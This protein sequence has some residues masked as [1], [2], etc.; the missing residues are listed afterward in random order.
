MSDHLSALGELQV[1]TGNDIAAAHTLLAG[2]F[3]LDPVLELSAAAAYL[4][5]GY[6]ADYESPLYAYDMTEEPVLFAIFTAKDEFPDIY[7]SLLSALDEKQTYDELYN[8]AEGLY[9]DLLGGAVYGWLDGMVYG[10][11]L[12]GY[13][14]A[15]Y[16][17]GWWEEEGQEWANLLS[18][19]FDMTEPPSYGDEGPSLWDITTPLVIDLESRSGCPEDCRIE[20]ALKNG[21]SDPHLLIAWTLRYLAS[22]TG[23]DAADMTTIS[24]AESGVDYPEWTQEDV[25]FIQGLYEECLQIVGLA[26]QGLE[27]INEHPEWIQALTDN[28]Q[29]VKARKNHDRISDG[30]LQWPKVDHRDSEGRAH[31]D[32]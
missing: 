20:R 27:F 1:T 7:V 14:V 22:M 24:I 2:I 8:L 12:V 6:P 16:E 21:E 4:C 26:E 15:L 17:D 3:T 5:P 18:T 11:P 9:N 25:D 13:G 31:P 10:I 32:A 28:V 30:G 29:R 19:A 23:N